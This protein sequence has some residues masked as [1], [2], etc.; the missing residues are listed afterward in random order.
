MSLDYW[1]LALRGLLMENLSALRLGEAALPPDSSNSS[2]WKLA[3]L[4]LLRGLLV[5]G[6]DFR[7]LI[8]LGDF[9]EDCLGDCFGDGS[10]LLSGLLTDFGDFGGLLPSACLAESMGLLDSTRS[11]PPLPLQA[12]ALLLSRR[13]L[14][15]FSACTAL[16]RLNRIS[17]AINPRHGMATSDEPM[18]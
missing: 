14:F 4:G 9:K 5:R 2:P 3:P 7:P 18:K 15:F 6:P 13:A 8:P 10:G 16:H 11:S 1:F 12:A 17:P